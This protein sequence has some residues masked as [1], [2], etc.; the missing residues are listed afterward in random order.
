MI[1]ETQGAKTGQNL[2]DA[3]EALAFMTECTLA[4]VSDLASMSRPKKSELKRQISIA[5]TGID[6]VKTITKPGRKIGCSRVSEIIDGDMSVETWAH[7]F[8]K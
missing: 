8:A 2:H 3:G 5:Q 1:A 4:T 7:K 6:W